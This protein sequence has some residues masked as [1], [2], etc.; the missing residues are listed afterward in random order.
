MSRASSSCSASAIRHRRRAGRDALRD[1]ARHPST[2]THVARKLVRHFISADAPPPA[3]IEHLAKV[4]RDTDG[5]LAEVSRALVGHPD[6]LKG[7]A[8]NIRQPWNGS[9]PSAASPA[10]RRTS[11]RSCSRSTCSASRSGRRRVRTAGRTAPPIG[12]APR[13]CARGSTLQPLPQGASATASTRP[14]SP[15]NCSTRRSRPR[16]RRRS[17][18]RNRNSRGSPC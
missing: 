12:A 14:S 2:A 15:I 6:A 11:A 13:A 16:R 9:R 8:A 18:G 17:G 3:L 10:R 1:I 5:D 4:F 7:E